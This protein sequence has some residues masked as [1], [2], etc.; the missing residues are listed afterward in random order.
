MQGRHGGSPYDGA[1]VITDQ[2]ELLAF[3]AKI[4]RRKGWDRVE[5]VTPT[6][7]I[8]HGLATVAQTGE[9]GGT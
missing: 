8:E 2:Y 4:T 5:R 9:L 1:V 6:E 7:P 3:G